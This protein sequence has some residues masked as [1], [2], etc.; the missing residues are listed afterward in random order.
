MPRLIVLQGPCAGKVFPVDRTLSIGRLS[1]NEIQLLDEQV[2]RQHARLEVADGGFLLVDLGSRRGVAVNGQKSDRRRLVH[3]DALTIG[4]SVLR[5]ESDSASEPPPLPTDA[6]EVAAPVPRTGGGR[7]KG[8]GEPAEALARRPTVAP[9]PPS[10]APTPL[11]K[12]DD[13]APAA[14]ALPEPR[15]RRGTPAPR[16]PLG[17]FV[18]I[19]LGVLILTIVLFA[20]RWVGIQ[21]AL[22]VLR[23]QPPP[24]KEQR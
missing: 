12:P 7:V 24:P 16:G 3:G 21:A 4:A 6:A 14:A 22:R 13:A 1:S 10:R 15:I 11:P 23:E 9:R 20:S 17:S 2:S 18:R 19:V 5:F 8:P